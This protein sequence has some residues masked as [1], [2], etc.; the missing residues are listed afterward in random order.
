MN[1]CIDAVVVLVEGRVLLGR[2]GGIAPSWTRFFHAGADGS[3]KKQQQL[4]PH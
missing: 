4:V 1:L 3:L 2:I